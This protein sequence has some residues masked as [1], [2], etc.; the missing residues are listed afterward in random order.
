MLH[1]DTKSFTLDIGS[2][3]KVPQLGGGIVINGRDS[4]VTV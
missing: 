1:R 2:G 4:L 3:L